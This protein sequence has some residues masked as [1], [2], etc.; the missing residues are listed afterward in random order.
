[1][2]LTAIN[3]YPVKSLKG[4]SLNNAD[5]DEFGIKNDRRWMLVD[6]DGE[7]VTQRKYPIMGTVGVEE[8]PD[9]LLFM[10]AG[11]EPLT[12][13]FEDFTKTLQTSVWGDHLVSMVAG[14]RGTTVA[15][16]NSVVSSSRGPSVPK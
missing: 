7:F 3:K 2:E 5:I 11:G 16:L 15:A 8:R 14:A 13:R 4:T 12:V 9:S 6:T 10:V 1:M